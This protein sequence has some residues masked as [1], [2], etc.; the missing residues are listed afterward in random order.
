MEKQIDLDRYKIYS[1]LKKELL[2]HIKNE[3]EKKHNKKIKKINFD[4]IINIEEIL[5]LILNDERKGIRLLPYIDLSNTSFKNQN[6]IGINFTDTNVKINPQSVKGKDFTST[7]LKG[8]DFKGCKWNDTRLSFTN[9]T[10]AKNVKIDPSTV[11]YPSL[12]GCICK[13]VDFKDGSFKGVGLSYTDL[14]GAL[15]VVICKKEVWNQDLT[16]T[17]LDENAI[18]VDSEYKTTKQQLQKSIRKRITQK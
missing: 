17:L 6:I 2:N 13:G 7:I 18:I 1:I 10:G 5:D 3:K 16:T 12:Y 8:L 11:M 9:F 14:R 15:N 4:D